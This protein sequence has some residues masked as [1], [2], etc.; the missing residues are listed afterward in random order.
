MLSRPAHRVGKRAIGQGFREVDAADLFRALEIGQRARHLE[1]AMIAARRQTHGR[2]GIGEELPSR[3]V[4][5]CDPV[6][7]LA[8]GF[9]I[10]TRPVTVVAIGLDLAGSSTQTLRYAQVVGTDGGDGVDGTE[11]GAQGAAGEEGS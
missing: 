8:V 5:R 6:Q 3:I 4:G 11:G 1:H 10:R 2:G 9:G 7:K